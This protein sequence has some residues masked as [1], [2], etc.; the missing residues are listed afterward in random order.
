MSSGN[1][2]YKKGNYREAYEYY[3]QAIEANPIA[4]Y[5]GNRAAASMMLSRYEDVISDCD[6]A[7]KRDSGFLK[8]YL[9]KAKAQLTLVSRAWPR[10]L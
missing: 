6:E 4:P 8:A 7:I 1:D 9:R 10:L 5:Y 2:S 3:T